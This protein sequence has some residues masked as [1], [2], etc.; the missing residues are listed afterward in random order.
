MNLY[1][2]YRMPEIS[3]VEVMS[4]GILCGS[5]DFDVDIDTGT[6]ETVGET[7]GRW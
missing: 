1:V 4:E 3:I 2:S 6:M 5:T 7:T